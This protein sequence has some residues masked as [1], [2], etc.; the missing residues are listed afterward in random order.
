MSIYDYSFLSSEGNEV[1]MDKYKGKTV[2]IVN[3]ASR[4]G[5]T[6][7]YES[8]EKFYK[9]NKEKGF[10]ILAFPCNQFGNQEPAEMNEIIEFCQTRF[11]V[12]FDIAL[13][14]EVNGE[15]AIE[16]YKYLKKTAKGNNDI[17]WNFEKFLV[18]RDGSI[19]NYSPDTT[20]S[21]IENTII[22]DLG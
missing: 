2:L 22:S 19:L 4:C 11:N 5:F 17:G 8:L 7:Q 3:T 10:E 16:L 12:T 20:I 13:K 14:S 18:L 15:N 21:D 9:A 1:H 6:E